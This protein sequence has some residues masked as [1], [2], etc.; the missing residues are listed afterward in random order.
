MSSAVP[1]IPSEVSPS[2]TVSPS[3]HL[4]ERTTVWDLAQIREGARIG[5]NCTIGRNVYIDHDVFIGDN[6][7]IQNNALIYWPARLADGV[8][9][10]PAAI[11]T[12]DRHPRAVNADLTA[13]GSDAWEPAGVLVQTGASIGARAVIGPG[14]HVGVW[15]MVGAGSVVTKDVP[16]H[17][18]MV[19]NPAERVGW[20]GKSGRRLNDDL[21]DPAT[22]ERYRISGG[23]LVLE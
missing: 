6:C 4:Q 7:K 12:N 23:E 18:L 11:L 21:V 17:A 14:V 19:G 13:K 10:G 8:F 9:I 2:A 20:V 5:V 3:A 1:E 15:A 16:A 22:G